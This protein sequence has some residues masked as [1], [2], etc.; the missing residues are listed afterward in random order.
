MAAAARAAAGGGGA[1]IIQVVWQV[2][3]WEQVAS[4]AQGGVL[5]D[6]SNSSTLTCLVAPQAAND[7]DDFEKTAP[8]KK[9][10]AT[11]AK[12]KITLPADDSSDVLA[13]SHHCFRSN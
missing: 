4:E 8:A 13:P 10:V 11:K 1:E 5:T 9:K 12:K 7:N 3:R 2:G 6:T